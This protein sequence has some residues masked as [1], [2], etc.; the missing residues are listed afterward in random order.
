MIRKAIEL[1]TATGPTSRAQA[2]QAIIAM[3]LPAAEWEEMKA[4]ILAGA[5]ARSSEDEAANG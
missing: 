5:S 4:V 3:R 2:A 1:Y